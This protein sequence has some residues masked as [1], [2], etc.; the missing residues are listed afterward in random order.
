[1]KEHYYDKLLNIKTTGDQQGFHNS[2]HYH[3]YEPT[4]YSALE[5][6]FEEYELQ[7]GDQVVDFGCGKGRLNFYMNHV[8]HIRATGIEMDAELYE[9]ALKNKERYLKKHPIG[10]GKVEFRQCLAE[11]YKID[12]KDNRFY[13]FNPFSVQVFMK[14][15]NNI[16]KSVEKAQREVDVVLYYPSEDYIYFLQNETA[17]QL[18]QEVE[19]HGF[20]NPREKFAIHR[21][22][23]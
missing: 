12:R 16:L 1:M 5:K 14:V 19:L 7:S 8:F 10:R 20:S 23:Y 11:D 22:S 15:I 3:R 21:L 13:F 17:F 9:A 2:M 6:L 18:V 4:P